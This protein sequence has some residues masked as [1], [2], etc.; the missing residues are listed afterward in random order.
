MSTSGST[1]TTLI[2]PFQYFADP[3]RARPVF[4]GFI[5]VGRVNGDPT[6]PDDQIPIQLICECGGSPISVT[7]PVRTGPG[8]L[9]IYNG[10]PAQIVVCQSSYSMTLQDKD[11]VQVY[12]S[13]NVTSGFSGF[14]NQPVTHISRDDAI[15]D[16]NTSRQII[17]TLE[18]DG[19]EYRRARDDTDYS[20]FSDNER[21]TDASGIRWVL[22]FNRRINT[23]MAGLVNNQNN[24]S[25]E[26][27]SLLTKDAVVEID[28][29]YNTGSAVSI[30][31]D[32]I[33]IDGNGFGTIKGPNTVTVLTFTDCFNSSIRN[34]T[35]CR[36][37][38]TSSDVGHL[39][40]LTDCEQVIVDNSN[41][42]T[43]AGTGT[44]VLGFSSNREAKK[45]RDITLQNTNIEGNID[46]SLNTN[47]IN[48]ADTIGSIIHNTR[49]T[50]I[51]EFAI[52]YK[53]ETRD[54]LL[55]NSIVTHSKIGIGYGQDTATTD[56]VSYTACTNAVLRS[57]DQGI[58]LGDASHNLFNNII[59]DNDDRPNTP[60][61]AGTGIRTT[62]NSNNNMFTG[63]LLA[64][65]S[66]VDAVRLDTENNFVSVANH[67]RSSSVATYTANARR[68]ITEIAHPGNRNSILSATIDNSGQDISG[69]TSNITYCHGTGEYIGSISGRWHW[70]DGIAT[71]VTP[72]PSYKHIL[73]SDETCFSAVLLPQDIQGGFTIRTP[74]DTFL[75]QNSANSDSLV[76]STISG[77]GLR[78]FSGTLRPLINNTMSCG[79]ASARWTEVFATNGT[80]NTSDER[81]K[82]IDDIPR[83]WLVAAK[84]IRQ[85]R[86]KWK[87]GG[88]R[89]HIGYGAQSV[90]KACIDAGIEDP[91][92]ISFLCKDRI[93][94]EDKEGNI[95]YLIDED[96]GE[97]KERWSLRIDELNT[98]KMAAIEAGI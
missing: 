70:R 93:E 50:G 67:T 68:N 44:A 16:D 65:A 71:N 92:E 55:S 72:L 28:A 78:I 29:L 36:D 43:I 41:F 32:N 85:I 63:I 79:N 94:T 38:V 8:G 34:I 33:N 98:L 53:N 47:G 17:R 22:N 39:I 82:V 97:I 2:S 61:T 35:L 87:D 20:M 80:I 9:P 46:A 37:N 75:I 30:R 52:E 54:S 95:K 7:Q 51:R 11:R 18:N 66:T 31:D 77:Y 59:I 62:G 64:G 88:K 69:P 14:I 12:H 26:I 96:T 23:T 83:S 3:T 21:F 6:N 89:W 4:N 56:D 73:E 15:A 40:S 58:I 10:N 1:R 27:R 42:R 81:Y 45:I 90:Y 48:L 5:Y 60:G 91:W 24:T 84:N 25:A 19:A 74:G 76:I 49:V 57:I 13:P 86:Y